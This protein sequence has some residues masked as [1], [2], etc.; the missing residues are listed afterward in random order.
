MRRAA[1][2][3]SRVGHWVSTRLE[4]TTL[5]MAFL[6]ERLHNKI[7]ADT[8]SK[9]HSNNTFHVIERIKVEICVHV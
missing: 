9:I 6:G 4:M 3:L 7:C 5:E 2:F 1:H 8:S